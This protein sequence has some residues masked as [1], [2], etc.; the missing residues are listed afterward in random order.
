L[1]S[2]IYTF[3]NFSKEINILVMQQ[4]NCPD[5]LHHDDAYVDVSAP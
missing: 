2:T 4:L 5:L 1:I 3:G